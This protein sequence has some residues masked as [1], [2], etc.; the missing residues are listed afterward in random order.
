MYV[1]KLQKT[2]IV[3]LRMSEYNKNTKKGLHGK[4]N[5]I[6]K[7]IKHAFNN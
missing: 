6:L 7:N 4:G 1:L 5:I 3:K 2:L